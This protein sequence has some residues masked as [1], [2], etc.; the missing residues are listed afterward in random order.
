M[1]A[2]EGYFLPH[3][4]KE[5]IKIVPYGYIIREISQA[6]YFVILVRLV[7]LMQARSTLHVVRAALAKFGLP[8]GHTKLN[9][10][11]G[12]LM[13]KHVIACVILLCIFYT[14]CAKK[15]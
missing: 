14:T 13:R 15:N 1:V 9:T 8:V 6:V 5:N 11:N 10:Q 7:R 4:W 12:E 2:L 3:F